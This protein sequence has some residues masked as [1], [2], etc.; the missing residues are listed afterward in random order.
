MEFM[1]VFIV[2]FG[3]FCYDYFFEI[4]FPLFKE[5]LKDCKEIILAIFRKLNKN[6]EDK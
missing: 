4:I 2:I 6:K 5:S 1:L 3:V